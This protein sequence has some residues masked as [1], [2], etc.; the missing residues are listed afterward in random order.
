[1]AGRGEPIP[2]VDAVVT[3]SGRD[4]D[5]APGN[6]RVWALAVL[7]FAGTA[8]A[9]AVV[10]GFARNAALALEGLQTTGSIVSYQPANHDSIRYEYQVAGKTYESSDRLPGG[11]AIDLA[12]LVRVTYWSR[13]PAISSVRDPRAELPSDI[14][15]LVAF[16]VIVPALAVWRLRSSSSTVD[17][18]Q[19]T[20]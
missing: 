9:V 2:Y 20:K 10:G 8:M 12:D 11:Q 14:G 15:I 7:L 19:V 13:N 18:P 1:M 6:R 17:R 5:I 3:G 16:S 4:R